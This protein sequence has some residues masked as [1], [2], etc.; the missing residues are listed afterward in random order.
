MGARNYSLEV[1]SLGEIILFKTDF[2]ILTTLPVSLADLCALLINTLEKLPLINSDAN[3][4]LPEH[5][6]R[7]FL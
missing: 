6:K 1:T 5:L 4:R 7:S 2:A 3:L